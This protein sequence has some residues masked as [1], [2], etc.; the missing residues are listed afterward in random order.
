LKGFLKEAVELEW[1]E[2][3]ERVG[4]K[5]QMLVLFLLGSTSHSFPNRKLEDSFLR[6]LSQEKA[7]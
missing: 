5:F 6:K 2:G 1:I 3:R 4:L 7:V